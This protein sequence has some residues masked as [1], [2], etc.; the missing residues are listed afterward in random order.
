MISEMVNV[1]DI[2]I[3]PETMTDTD[4]SAC[5]TLLQHLGMKKRG[6]K[7]AIASVSTQFSSY[8]ADGTLKAK[9]R[10]IHLF[11]TDI[12]GDISYKKSDFFVVGDEPIIVDTDIGLIAF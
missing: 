6:G 5:E 11:D 7:H 8:P 10:K 3:S 9:H 1:D 2:D 12:P 4:R